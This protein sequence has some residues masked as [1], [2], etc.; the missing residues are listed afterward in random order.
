MGLLATLDISAERARD[1]IRVR[2]TYLP[3]SIL[4]AKRA[5]WG[6][7][8]NFFTSDIFNNTLL[9]NFLLRDVVGKLG[10]GMATEQTERK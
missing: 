2:A 7:H 1:E 8:D 10:L 4:R 9:S 5:R 6:T 3:A